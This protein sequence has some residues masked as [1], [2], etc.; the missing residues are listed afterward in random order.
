[1]SIIEPPIDKLLNETD[2]DRFL[3]CSVASKRADD[4]NDMMRGQRD[5]AMQAQNALDIARATDRKPLS[6][7]F[8][9]IAQGDVNCNPDSIDINYH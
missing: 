5:R 3:L 1:M 4:I 8:N 9:E 2:N 6:I 7:A